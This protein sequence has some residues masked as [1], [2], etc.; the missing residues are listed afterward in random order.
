MEKCRVAKQKVEHRLLCC[1]ERVSA[2]KALEESETKAKDIVDMIPEKELASVLPCNEE[3]ETGE[4]L[5]EAA[6][7]T[8]ESGGSS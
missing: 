7:I 3:E 1:Q 6:M 2:A 8:D 4:E 5:R